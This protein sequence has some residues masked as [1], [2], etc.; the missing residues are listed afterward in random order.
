LK[1]DSTFQKNQPHILNAWASYDWANSVYNLTI[2][3]A[4]FP[5]YYAASTE[6]AF[7]GDKVIF[8]G[9][10][11]TSTVLYAYAIAMSFLLAA[12]LSPLLSGVADYGGKKK[13]LMKFFT[14]TGSAACF[15]LFFFD[16]SNV[17]LGIIAAVIA[18]MGYSGAVVFYISF[19]PEI[20]TDDRLDDVSARGFSMGFLGS[21]IQLLISLIIVFNHGALGISEGFATRLSFLFVA[22]WWV[23]FAQI[24]F[25]YLPNPSTERP[26]GVNLFKK[27]FEELLK[28]WQNL[29]TMPNTLR[30]LA[31]FFFYSM[32]AQSIMLLATIFGSKELQ[33][34]TSKLVGT[35]FILQLVG[36][37]GAYLFAFISKKKGNK[38][39]IL[40]MLVI[41]I[42]TCIYG[43]FLQ[44]EMEFYIMAAAVGLVMG[45][46]HLSRSTYAKLIPANTPDTTSYF[47]FYD[48]MEKLATAFG[49][50][51]YGLI[52]A[53]TGSMRISLIALAV[54]F[55]VG[56][57][58]LSTVKIPRGEVSV[59]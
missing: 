5:I 7:G 13:T 40:T 27:G 11:I 3:A 4:I 34:E 9:M 53:I 2:T 58:L 19:L 49:P 23:G 6:A 48:V 55:V 29:K 44:S 50:F 54:Y 36:I 38:F 12:I 24:A 32:G 33:L 43:F 28:V 10:E 22:V 31:A 45:G 42:I 15:T 52:E 30:F 1:T 21:V 47:S 8:F 14:Y 16:G 26:K 18:S 51:S 59:G 46:F 56:I 39:S 20:A 25:Y 57:I 37:A 35:I 41:W 17:E